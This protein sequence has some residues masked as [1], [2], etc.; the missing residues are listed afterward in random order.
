MTSYNELDALMADIDAHCV[1]TPPL[2]GARVDWSQL[3]TLPVLA[4][5]SEDEAWYRAQVTGE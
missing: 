1:T 4:K 5:F 2:A 3:L